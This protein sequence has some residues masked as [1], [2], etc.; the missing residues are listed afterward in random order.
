VE[1]IPLSTAFSS[2]DAG[3]GR[4]F[5]PVPL[6]GLIV[7]AYAAFLA[8]SFI[9]HAWLVGPDGRPLAVDFISFWAAGRLALAG[10]AASAY[11]FAAHHAA[12][13]AATG[14]PFEGYYSWYYPPTFF[15]LMAPV[16]ALPYVPALVAWSLAS[17]AGFLAAIRLV[18]PRRGAIVLA[19]AV[20]VVL[21]NFSVGQNGFLSAGL[22]AAALA[23]IDRRPVVAGLLIAGLTYKPQFG[24]LIPLALAC[25]GYW[26]V[27]LSAVL[28][29]LA[30]A[31]LSLIVFGI[32]PWQG[33]L[34]S[35]RV[36]YQTILVDNLIGAEK[37]QSVFGLVRLL[38]AG[39]EAAWIAQY[40]LAVPLALFVGWVWWRPCPVDL[41]AAALAAATAL[42]TPYALIYDLVI[43]IVPVA[44]L[45]RSG[46]SRG[47]AIAALLACL[48]LLAFVFS[49]GAV[50]LPASLIVMG[51]VVRRVLAREEAGS[52]PHPL[53]HRR[54]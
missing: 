16:A 36:A 8:G 29:S 12:E 11:D 6:A 17:L 4:R 39:A 10:E 3:A 26:R 1:D 46:L 38:G 15:L 35:I 48:F 51:M 44:F 2:A 5:D 23:L 50:G 37:L 31:G 45:A 13:L 14:V 22:M 28:A 43:L 18:L 33:F 27:F 49:T 30:L 32:A 52:L 53:G 24:V 34:G 42:V 25:G 21:W 7:V 47:E 19:A 54:A 41:K 9:A 40:A 20:P